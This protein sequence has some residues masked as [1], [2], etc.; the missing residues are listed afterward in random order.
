MKMEE[1]ALA[2][3]DDEASRARLDKLRRDLADKTE[4]LDALTARWEREKSGLNRV[5]ELK[6]RLDQLRTQAETAQRQGDF[7][8]ASR[9]MYAEIPAAE[10]SL[11]EAAATAE[12][13]DSSGPMVKEEVGADDVADVV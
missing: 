1:L 12:D 8:T 3:E 4:E 11:A 7:E 5:G 2:K 10:R 6:Q 13:T 9:L